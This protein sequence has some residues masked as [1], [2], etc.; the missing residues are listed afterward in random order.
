MTDD[1]DTMFKPGQR[2]ERF[3]MRE[4]LGGGGQGEVW[5][6]YDT[7][8]ERVCAIKAS[9]L[10]KQDVDGARRAMA[11]GDMMQRIDH[12]NIV[13][14]FEAGVTEDGTVWLAMERLYGQ[15]LRELLIERR[16]PI[17]FSIYLIEEIAWALDQAHE[18]RVIHRDVKPENIFITSDFLVILLDLGLGKFIEYGLQ[19][20]A[21]MHAVGTP[22]Y[23]APEQAAAGNISDARTDLYQLGV[24]MYEVLAGHP[25]HDV[26][27]QRVALARAH[28]V[29]DPT[30]LTEH[31]LPGYLDAIVQRCMQKELAL[32]YLTAADLARDLR[33]ARRLLEKD[34]A[35]GRV[36]DFR[37]PGEPST[38]DGANARR[39]SR[40][41]LPSSRRTDPSAT[42]SAATP[43][44]AAGPFG[45]E[46]LF[47]LERE[48]GAP[49]S[50]A[51]QPPPRREPSGRATPLPPLGGT[52]LLG[53]PT[54][55]MPPPPP[56]DE[57]RPP[58]R[59]ASP[60][61]ALRPSTA[62]STPAT[63]PRGPGP[64][65]KLAAPPDPPPTP[66]LR[67]N[68]LPG[69]IETSPPPPAPRQSKGALARFLPRQPY[70]TAILA[71]FAFVLTL[72]VLQ[73]A[74]SPGRPSPSAARGSAIVAPTA[75]PSEPVP[76]VSLPPDPTPP[77]P[78]TESPRPSAGPVA[79]PS[80]STPPVEQG[81]ASPPHPLPTAVHSAT[82]PSIK[83]PRP[84]PA[85]P[86]APLAGAPVF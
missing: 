69:G 37:L 77:P 41:V 6:A 60:A 64:S 9:K 10:S 4:R 8:A 56:A 18:L 36:F 62:P 49:S 35:D 53:M 43:P 61:S 21:R 52:T 42:P 27:H 73:W 2:F 54:L 20:T 33:Q 46:R 11:E 40:I 26:L 25:F 65:T 72:C 44:P 28:M 3:L 5:E 30:P 34:L 58:A 78:P 75:E 68:T 15:S 71:V 31:G 19:S 48:T 50:P 7:R 86:A 76:A 57:S 29:R 85:K 38:L 12:A 17:R 24:V 32:R 45:T 74:I 81:P 13:R 70:S 83:P 23:M 67:G 16:L 80:S 59:G 51:H 66:S 84:P 39:T 82:P 14:V 47:P 79:P 55:S 63:A 1:A 22:Q